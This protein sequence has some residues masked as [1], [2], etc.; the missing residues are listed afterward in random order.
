MYDGMFMSD[1]VITLDDDAID[2]VSGGIAPAVVA[3]A[4]AVGGFAVGA[5]AGYFANR[6]PSPRPSNSSSRGSRGRR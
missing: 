5:A 6:D 4:L 1:D 2:S 3:G